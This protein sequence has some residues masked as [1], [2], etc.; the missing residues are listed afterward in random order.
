MTGDVGELGDG[1]QAIAKFGGFSIGPQ[2]RNQVNRPLEDLL[3]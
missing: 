1:N 3:S 2:V